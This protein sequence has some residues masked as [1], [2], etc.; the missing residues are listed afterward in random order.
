VSVV[1]AAVAAAAF[2][3]IVNVVLLDY[4]A[5]RQDRVGKL[6]PNYALVRPTSVPEPLPPRRPHELP[7]D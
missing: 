4:G 7:D 3:L 5:Q 1:L 6:T 2:A